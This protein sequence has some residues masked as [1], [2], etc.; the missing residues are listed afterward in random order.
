M[1]DDIIRD[2]PWGKI[3]YNFEKDSFSA[4]V[5]GNKEPLPSS[6]IGIAWL[7]IGGCNLKCIHC[8]GNAE[9]LSKIVL[10]TKEILH[11]VDKIIEAKVMRVVLCGGEPM[12]R[13]DI[14]EVIERLVRGG[15][16]VVLGTNGSFITDKNVDRLKICTRVEISL[17]GSTSGLNNYIRPSRI[18]SGDSWKETIRALRLCL[19]SNI[20]LRV[21]TAVNSYNQEDI[22]NIAGLLHDIGVSD[23]A[24]SWT[25]PAGRAR[26]IFERLRPT[27]EIVGS[28]V[29]KARM[30]YPDMTIR[31]SHRGSTFTKFYCLIFPDGQIGT[32]DF[33]AGDK[34]MYGS[35][36]EKSIESV[37]S[38]DNYNLPNHFKKW[39][40]D[41][42]Y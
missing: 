20:K 42:V 26:F 7:V 5:A 10:S 32:E 16:S 23:W 38:A 8:Y 24:L 29:Q 21:L 15:V 27:K 6:P 13:N 39:V 35:L 28:N 41:R 11:I 9:E 3:I 1:K 37:W 31:Y 34:I 22:V 14:F 12:L 17:D 19:K 40:G 30:S 33:F 25:I 2:E 18:R 36:L 4:I